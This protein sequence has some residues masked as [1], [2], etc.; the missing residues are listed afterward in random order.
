MFCDPDGARTRN[1]WF[2]RPMLYH[3]A[4]GP[5]LMLLF[6]NRMSPRHPFHTIHPCS[7]F[8]FGL[9]TIHLTTI[10]SF[11]LPRNYI[12][13]LLGVIHMQHN[14]NQ[15]LHT[16]SRRCHHP[17]LLWIQYSTLSKEKSDNNLILYPFLLEF[18]IDLKNQ[19]S[20][21]LAVPE[22]Q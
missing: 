6:K 10:A 19:I 8:I 1:L 13:I 17:V 14:S 3:W 20:Q 22:Q 4:T 12:S 9:D 7:C 16:F 21:W 2:R 15:D 11:S 18:K 5:I